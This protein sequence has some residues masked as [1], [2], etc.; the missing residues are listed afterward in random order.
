M[1]KNR[2]EGWYVTGGSG[3]PAATMRYWMPT[4]IRG[5]W[6]APCYVDDPEAIRTKA[7]STYGE[8]QDVTAGPRVT[9]EQG[10]ATVRAI[11]DGMAAAMAGNAEVSAAIDRYVD[12]AHLHERAADIALLRGLAE[13]FDDTPRQKRLEEIANRIESG[14]YSSTGPRYEARPAVSV[15]VLKPN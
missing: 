5:Y 6:S 3:T 1:T 14:Y 12:A 9:F 13:V 15:I 10:Y 8:T 2:E 7:R 4:G 11:W